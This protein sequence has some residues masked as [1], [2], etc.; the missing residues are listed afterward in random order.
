LN[1]YLTNELNFQKTAQLAQHCCLESLAAAFLRHVVASEQPH[2][3]DLAADSQAELS[4]LADPDCHC[5]VAHCSQSYHTY[6]LVFLLFALVCYTSSDCCFFA[7][8]DIE[9]Q[10]RQV[11]ETDWMSQRPLL[12]GLAGKQLVLTARCLVYACEGQAW[13]L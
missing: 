13:A 1:L 7:A 2:S 8:L 6:S 9:Y 5:G 3:E 10:K 11:H 12:L 4:G